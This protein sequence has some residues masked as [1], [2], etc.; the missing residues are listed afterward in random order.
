LHPVKG[1]ENLLC[2]C[3]ILQ[4]WDN[5]WSL[6]IA[7]AGNKEYTECLQEQ[8]K[9]T[10]LS[11]KVKMVGE[12]QEY[13]KRSLFESASL[14][15]VPSHTENFGMVVAEALAHAVPVIASKGT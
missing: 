7:G 8:I 1:I 5:D 3:S 9:K 15:V 12:V 14:V 13:Q 2:A 11:R 6:T 10:N 4:N